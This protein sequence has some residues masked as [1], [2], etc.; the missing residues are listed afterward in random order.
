MLVVDPSSDCELMRTLYIQ[1]DE[2]NWVEVGWYQ[3]GA[4]G[5]LDICTDTLTPHVL[6]YAFVYGYIKCKPSVPTLSAGEEYSFKVANPDHD[7]DFTYYWDSDST[8]DQSLGSYS[9]LHAKGYPQA[10]DERRN[11]TDDSLRASFDMTESL[12]SGGG[13]H[14]FPTPVRLEEYRDTSGW[15]VCSWSGNGLVVR[16]ESTC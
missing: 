5:S 9:T 10:S 16:S 4:D 2:V 6:V 13:W 11:G 8:P 14:S 7:L 3:D 15:A 1:K 12:G